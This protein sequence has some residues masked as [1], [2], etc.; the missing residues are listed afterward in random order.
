MTEPMRYAMTRNRHG[1]AV[2]IRRS[3]DPAVSLCGVLLQRDDFPATSSTEVCR[4]CQRR[5]QRT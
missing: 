1:W 3:D 5:G 2:H 4:N